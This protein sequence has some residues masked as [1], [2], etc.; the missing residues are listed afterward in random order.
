MTFYILGYLFISLC[1]AIAVFNK[2]NAKDIAELIASI[3]VGLIWPVLFGSR[4]IYK[5]LY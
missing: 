3:F 2:N 4:I 5:I 1:T